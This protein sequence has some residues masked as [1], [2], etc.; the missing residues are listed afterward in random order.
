MK[1]TF[2]KK[3]SHFLWLTFGLVL[4][5][6]V[7]MAFF[8]PHEWAETTN[9]ETFINDVAFVVPVLYGLKNHTPPYTPYW[10]MFYATFWCLAPIFFAAGAASTFFFPHESYGKMKLNKPRLYIFGYLFFL[11]VSMIPFFLPFIGNF[12]NPLFNQMSDFLPL[13]LLAWC[14]TA[15][16]PFTL[17]WATGCCYH[18]FI[19]NANH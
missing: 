10:G 19:S 1:S 8:F 3:Q 17:G 12:P 14:T 15:L 16:S 18:R 6:G 5:H 13:R 4:C 2:L 11:I 7:Y 9:A